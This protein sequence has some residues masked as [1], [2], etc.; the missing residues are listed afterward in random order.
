MCEKKHK[1]NIIYELE[2]EDFQNVLDEEDVVYL[3]RDEIVQRVNA[4]NSGDK[5]LELSNRGFINEK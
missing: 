2:M 5:Y 1:K 4:A 3:I